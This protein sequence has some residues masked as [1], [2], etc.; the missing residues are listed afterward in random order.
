MALAPENLQEMEMFMS[1]ILP[2]KK[3]EQDKLDAIKIIRKH[4]S[5]SNISMNASNLL[6]FRHIRNS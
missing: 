5:S 3:T 4:L 1:S 2:S 6:S